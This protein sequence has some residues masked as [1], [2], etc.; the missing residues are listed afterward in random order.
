METDT[1]LIS[2]T[3]KIIIETKYVAG[4]LITGR[5]NKQK[6]RSSHL[7]QLASYL[8]NVGEGSTVQPEGILLYPAVH[9]TPTNLRYEVWGYRVS[10]R[11]INLNRSWREIHA[12]LLGLLAA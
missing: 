10:A 7:Y 5:Y 9:E 6:L 12:D 2:P 3:R 8:K 1:S 11:T 4:A